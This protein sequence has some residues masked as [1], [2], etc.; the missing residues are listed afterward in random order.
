MEIVVA[1][2]AIIVTQ[3]PTLTA[4][5]RHQKNRYPLEIRIS[6]NRLEGIGTHRMKPSKNLDGTKAIIMSDR[7][8]YLCTILGV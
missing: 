7:Y 1:V 5:P 2:A 4:V 3:D 8:G 6:I